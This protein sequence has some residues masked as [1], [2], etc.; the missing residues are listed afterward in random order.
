MVHKSA[1]TTPVEHFNKYR[2]QQD[3]FMRPA[4]YIV[5]FC[6]TFVVLSDFCSTEEMF[7]KQF[8][9]TE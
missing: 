4:D 2:E 3:Y 9:P 7:P 6:V 5:D 8:F 1:H